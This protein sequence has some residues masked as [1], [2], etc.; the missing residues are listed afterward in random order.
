MNLHPVAAELFHEEKET[1]K[2]TDRQTHDEGNSLFRNFA[3]EPKQHTHTHTHTH[4][5]VLFNVCRLM[6]LF[7]MLFSNARKQTFNTPEFT[8]LQFFLCRYQT[9]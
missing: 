6:F 4:M 8:S 2:Q 3:K 5:H 9:L 7:N 1:E